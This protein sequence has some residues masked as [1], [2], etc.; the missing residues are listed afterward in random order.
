M[1]QSTEALLTTAGTAGGCTGVDAGSDSTATATARLL[2][3]SSNIHMC[4]STLA[5]LLEEQVCA[6][7]R[8]LIVDSKVIADQVGAEK[9]KEEEE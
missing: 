8:H 9:E 3:V 2:D 6:I 5:L 1:L 4:A 7:R